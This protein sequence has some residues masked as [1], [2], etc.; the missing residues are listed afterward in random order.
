[1]RALDNSQIVLATN[2]RGKIQE[3]QNL[4][5][6]YQ[7]SVVSMGSVGVQSPP[8]TESTFEGNAKIKAENAML[9][10][11]MIA[12]ADDSGLEV[13]ALENA[14]GVATAD[15]AEDVSG[16]D[17]NA[18]MQ[19]LWCELEDTGVSLPRRASFRTVI[20]VIWTD[21]ECYFFNG[22][23]NGSLVWPPRGESGFGFDPMFIPDGSE[24]T[25]AEMSVAEKSAISH[26][27]KALKSLAENCFEIYR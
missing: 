25:F 2:N 7:V 5:L 12:V 21:G 8:E 24:L 18:A 10:S 16:R 14:L 27:G 1:M 6:K 20:C 3:Y 15:Y 23:V 26:R 11:G 17:Y 19:R 13:E 22:K 4:L 9:R